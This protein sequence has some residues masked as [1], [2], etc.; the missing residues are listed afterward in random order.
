[1]HWKIYIQRPIPWEERYIFLKIYNFTRG[2]FVI[3][4][5]LC[6]KCSVFPCVKMHYN[7][8][9][10]FCLTS[11]VSQY[12]AILSIRFPHRLSGDPSVHNVKQ[13]QWLLGHF[14]WENLGYIF[15]NSESHT[16]LFLYLAKK[17]LREE[18]AGDVISLF[19][20]TLSLDPAAVEEKSNSSSW[21]EIVIG[22][23]PAV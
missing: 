16:A 2:D 20:W 21:G 6:A 22:F 11:Q 5:L 8:S 1:M 18:I 17:F 15:Y 9:F 14:L 4:Q 3:E 19:F 13:L 12:I 10:P 7:L 23:W